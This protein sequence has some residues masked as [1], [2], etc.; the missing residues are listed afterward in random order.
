[1]TAYTAQSLLEILSLSLCL[2]ACSLSQINKI[3]AARVAQ[4]FSTTFGP[5]RGPRDLGLSPTSG[6]LHGA[7]FSLSVSLP[8]SVCVSHE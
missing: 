3:R 5:G 2:H 1:M 4:G 6:S 8:L 7:C